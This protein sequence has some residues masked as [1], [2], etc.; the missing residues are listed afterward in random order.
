MK[1]P[2][3]L[4][5]M[6][7]IEI[8]V[9]ELFL[10]NNF[11]DNQVPQ[12]VIDEYFAK[13]NYRSNAKNYKEGS[14]KYIAEIDKDEEIALLP[15][16]NIVENFHGLT[17]TL[18]YSN[19]VEFSILTYTYTRSGYDYDMEESYEVE[20]TAKFL[21]KNVYWATD[22]VRSMDELLVQDDVK[23]LLLMQQEQGLKLNIYERLKSLGSCFSFLLQEIVLQAHLEF[24]PVKYYSE[25]AS[26]GQCVVIGD[27]NEETVYSETELEKVY[28]DYLDKVKF[29]DH[30][31]RVIEYRSYLGS[32]LKF[33]REHSSKATQL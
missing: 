32:Y 20:V 18:D 3:N 11:F 14:A 28:Q 2:F 8:N 23:S 5:T 22:I 19:K 6:K 27:K 17:I 10:L 12:K 1:N 26:M 24:K 29:Y 25:Y 30:E 9:S 7:N 13:K 31:D 21:C 33:H 15:T 16:H 4:K